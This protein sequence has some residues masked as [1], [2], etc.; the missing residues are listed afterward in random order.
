MN[1]VWFSLEAVIIYLNTINQMIIVMET[2]YVFFE[3]LQSLG[4]RGDG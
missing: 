3:V 2:R 4:C 1:F